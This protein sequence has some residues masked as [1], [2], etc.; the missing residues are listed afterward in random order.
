MQM[1]A[2]LEAAIGR[3][4]AAAAEFVIGD[5][6]S[7]KA[8]FSHRDDVCVANP[9]N[10]K[11]HG[12]TEVSEMIDRAANLWR[13]GEVIGFER[14]AQAVGSDLA[15]ILEIERFH[16]KIG[17]AEESSPIELRVTSVLRLE[18]GDWKVVHR[19]ADP[20]TTPQPA[21]SV[22]RH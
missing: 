21:D 9:F 19:H 2:G 22:I 20:I 5:P 3:Y 7:Y 14:V 1:P 15:Y 13:D 8:V 6:A 10:P 16:A 17:D 12:W 18:D 4:H 11:A